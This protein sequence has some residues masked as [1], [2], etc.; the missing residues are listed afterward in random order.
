MNFPPT[1]SGR[2]NNIYAVIET[3]LG[4]RNKYNYNTNN[5]FYELDKI[6]PAGTCFPMDFGFIPH[7]LGEDGDPLD[8][9]V[10]MD[11]K[12][13]TGCLVE[14]RVI[15]IMEAEQKE[16]GGKKERND[17][18][19]AVSVASHDYS[20][21]KHIKEMNKNYVKE[22]THFFEYYNNM[23]GKKFKIK[24]LKGPSEGLELI[25]KNMVKK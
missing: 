6:L 9:L 16:K 13:F 5:G 22:L 8:V 15:G 21:L 4:S 20:Q 24:G 23:S 12:S 19:I 11:I 1:F 14:C 3:P 17:R 18:V 10:I 2:E 25:K 7:T